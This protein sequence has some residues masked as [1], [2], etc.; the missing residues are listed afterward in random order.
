MSERTPLT[1]LSAVEYI[2]R[3]QDDTELV[4]PDDDCLSY[5]RRISV[6]RPY[7]ARLALEDPTCSE[8]GSGLA[9]K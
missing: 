6:D 8:C 3:L 5:P 2:E 1:E 4:C 7:S 9:V